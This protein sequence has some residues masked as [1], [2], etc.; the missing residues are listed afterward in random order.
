MKA[1]I[2]GAVCIGILLYLTHQYLSKTPADEGEYTI[3]EEQPQKRKLAFASFLSIDVGAD[4]GDMNE[5]YFISLRIMLYDLFHNPQTSLSD[6]S[7]TFLVIVT[8]DIP[9]KKRELLEKEGA[10]VLRVEKIKGWGVSGVSRYRD[11][12]SKLLLFRRTEYELICFIDADH[13][14]V[15]RGLD[16]VFF[17]P[18]TTIAN[19]LHQ[20]SERK[21]DE[22]QQPST[23]VF[24]GK[25]EAYKR[26]HDFPIPDKGY[27]NGGFWV[28]RPSIELYEHYIKVRASSYYNT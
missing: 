20:P 16:G 6:K 17:D 13:I 24:A 27:L 22:G 28:M 4:P 9:Q 3:V 10:L 11:M 18:A 23:Y 15:G 25:P 2:A 1:R 5:G 7:I 8:D 14:I 26:D 21:E 12:Y 19:N